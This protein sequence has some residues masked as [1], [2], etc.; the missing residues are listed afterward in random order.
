MNLHHR[1]LLLIGTVLTFVVAGLGTATAQ[2]SWE[3][4]KTTCEQDY[5][6]CLRIRYPSSQYLEPPPPELNECNR[7]GVPREAT[8]LL[9]CA[10]R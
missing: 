6:F 7:S 9:A 10:K 8:C 5:A 2:S 4:C 3:K 1:R